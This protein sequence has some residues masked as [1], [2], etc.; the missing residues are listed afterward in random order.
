MK[1]LKDD[2]V[3][4]LTETGYAVFSSPKLIKAMTRLPKTVYDIAKVGAIGFFLSLIPLVIQIYYI[5]ENN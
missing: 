3:R 5:L 1:D 2:D 4:F